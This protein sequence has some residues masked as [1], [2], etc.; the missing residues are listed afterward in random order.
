MLLQ[1][2]SCT[3]FNVA[4]EKMWV[5]KVK[6]VCLCLEIHEPPTQVSVPWNANTEGKGGVCLLSWSTPLYLNIS[7]LSCNSYFPF[8]SQAGSR[9]LSSWQHLKS[10]Q[11]CLNL[12]VALHSSGPVRDEQ[13]G[14]LHCLGA[15]FSTNFVI[16][17]INL[18]CEG[19]FK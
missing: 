5:T 12:N 2:C 13:Q 17:L 4:L 10:W 8:G 14:A 3:C 15:A 16:L 6:S 1:N 7:T 11:C 19:A 9:V 18:F